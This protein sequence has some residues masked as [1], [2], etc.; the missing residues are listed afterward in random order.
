MTPAITL[1]ILR[2]ATLLTL[3][4]GAGSASAVIYT[5]GAEPACTHANVQAA[6]M[7][8]PA[9]GSHIVRIA[10]SLI[11]SA[12]ALSL[13]GRHVTV[14]GGLDDCADTTPSG[15][16]TLSGAGGDNDSVLTVIGTG[17]DVIL[18]HLSIIRGDEVFDGFGGGI[19]FRGAGFLTAVTA[20]RCPDCARRPLSAFPASASP[21]R[22]HIE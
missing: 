18:E 5:V 14:I 17:N 21:I 1:H 3:T 19:D 7:A 11:Y 16:T 8:I 20:G 13:A 15:V 9:T 4:V 6:F 12:Q 10:N 2:L 22:G